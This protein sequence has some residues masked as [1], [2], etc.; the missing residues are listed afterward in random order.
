MV[1]R[2]LNVDLLRI[3]ATFLVIILHVLGKGGI[4]NNTAVGG[5][6]YWTAWFLE[7]A[8][9]CAVN[10]FA[11]ISGYVMADKTVKFKNIV[12]LWFQVLFY[13]VIIS[14]L[15]FAFMPQTLT[16]KNIFNALFPVVGKQWWYVSSYMGMMLFIPFINP[17][18]NSISKETFTKILFI[19]LFVGGV[20]D[21]LMQRKAFTLN[22]GYSTVW[23]LIVY[24]FG[25]YIKKF[26]IQ[27]KITVLKSL[28]GFFAAVTVTFISKFVIFYFTEKVC[29][30]VMNDNVFVSY[31][32]ITILLAAVFLLLFCLNVRVC[33]FG[34]KIISLLSPLALGIYLIHVHPMVFKYIFKNAFVSFA[35][36]S[37]IIMLLCVFAATTVVFMVCALIEWIRIKLFKLIK[38]GKL[39]EIIDNKFNGLYLKV[40]KD[41]E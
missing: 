22:R 25:A 21:C 6:N 8:S 28:L 15:F 26:N 37:P 24:L 9:Y 31:R 5:L 40:F 12:G 2:N 16:T 35:D 41:T 36:K 18:I 20:V 23:L 14:S 27:E 29:G 13:S 3:V 34:E 17:A 10:C 7:I 33:G 32:S 30:K 4:L 39:C 38:V 19:V 1:K 11:L